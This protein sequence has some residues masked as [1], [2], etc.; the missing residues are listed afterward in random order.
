MFKN[1]TFQCV[2]FP[3]RVIHTTYRHYSN[4]FS[5]FLKHRKIVENKF[6]F[7][8]SFPFVL[9][10][11]IQQTD[12][13]MKFSSDRLYVDFKTIAIGYVGLPVAMDN[14]VGY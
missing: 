5:T 10:W 14:H 2:R 1:L 9:I 12:G 3:R 4:T 6:K 11:R 7:F 8:S 13:R